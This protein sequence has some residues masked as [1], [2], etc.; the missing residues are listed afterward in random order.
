MGNKC[1]YGSRCGYKVAQ[2]APV[3][4]QPENWSSYEKLN[5]NI[6]VLGSSGVS[7]SA[8]ISRFIDGEYY[9]G[10]SMRRPREIWLKMPVE[11]KQLIRLIITERDQAPEKALS[12]ATAVLLVYDVSDRKS[13]VAAQESWQ[14]VIRA[15]TKPGTPVIVCAAKAEV[16][17][18]KRKVGLAEGEKLARQVGQESSPL[19]HE[20]SATDDFGIQE[21]FFTAAVKGVSGIDPE[22][23]AKANAYQTYMFEMMSWEYVNMPNVGRVVCY[24]SHRPSDCVVS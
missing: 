14:S 15:C 18:V 5:A 16:L 19:Y 24:Q 1:G 8:I 17:P 13:F 23:R 20:I 6:V 12:N 7:K 21:A 9:E 10:P 3:E 22:L 2:Q 4:M 11:S